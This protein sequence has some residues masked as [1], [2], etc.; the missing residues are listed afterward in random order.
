MF[1]ST[2]VS[3]SIIAGSFAASVRHD[4]D[5]PRRA[6]KEDATV[7]ELQGDHTLL[8]DIEYAPCSA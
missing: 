1:S 2:P 3:S 5:Y 4:P 7:V 8:R 6:T